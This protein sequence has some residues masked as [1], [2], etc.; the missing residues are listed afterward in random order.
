MAASQKTK[1]VTYS[2][3]TLDIKRQP[4]DT[5]G[6]NCDMC[7]YK[8]VTTFHLAYFRYFGLRF[9][10]FFQREAVLDGEKCM[11]FCFE[12][13]PQVIA[14][15]YKILEQRVKALDCQKLPTLQSLC[16]Y[17]LTQ[18]FPQME[19]DAFSSVIPH[20]IRENLQTLQHA[21]DTLEKKLLHNPGTSIF[22][23]SIF[24]RYLYKHYGKFLHGFEK[25]ALV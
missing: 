5:N 8:T 2:I 7:K 19:N 21:I 25:E 20:A 15:A 10:S 1:Q 4:F 13:T 11:I 17:T 16:Y 9:E 6:C 18:N 3:K 12:I 22:H 14:Q 24:P 23:L